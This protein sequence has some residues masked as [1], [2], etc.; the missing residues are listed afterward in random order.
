MKNTFLLFNKPIFYF[1]F[2]FSVLNAPLAAQNIGINRSNPQESLDVNGNIR[3]NGYIRTSPNPPTAGQVLSATG[4]GDM[5][6]ADAPSP[7]NMQNFPY[8]A[9]FR[10]NGTTSTAANWTVP[11]GI[12]KIFVELWTG[13]QGGGT[14]YGGDGGNY[15]AITLEVTEG[16]TINI[17]AGGG[18]VGTT[19]AVPSTFGGSSS[20]TAS[21]ITITLSSSTITSGSGIFPIFI[22]SEPGKY[23]E[24]EYHQ[25]SATDFV[26]IIRG[27]RGGNSPHTSLPT[28]GKGTTYEYNYTT[29]SATSL[30]LGEK[31]LLPGGGGGSSKVT[32]SSGYDGGP[33]MVIIHY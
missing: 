1:L 26:Q 9:A 7:V 17:T 4:R 27:A 30:G 21:G 14:N 28:G 2:I 12:S 10:G 16:S 8:L 25:K 22:P 15:G 19:S 6:W 32:L 20:I 24:S 29:F 23:G 11:T 33:G 31:G 3:V 13:G 5:A 18:G